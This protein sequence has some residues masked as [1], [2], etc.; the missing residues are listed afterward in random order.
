MGSTIAWILARHGFDVVVTDRDTDS[1]T[2]G[3]AR[4]EGRAKADPS[5]DGLSVLSVV[6]ARI[7]AA[8]DIESAVS[9]ADLVIEATSE[10]RD[11][12]EK[13]LR[14][15]SE[16]LPQHAILATNTSSY[17][18]D[19]LA[20]FLPASVRSRFV[21]IHFFNPADLVPGVEVI[22]HEGT[23]VRVLDT[24]ML[25]MRQIG[26]R[27]SLIR[28][29]PGFVANR[30][31]LALF[32]EAVACVDEGVATSEEIDVIVSNTFGYRLPAF[33]PFQVADM[34][35]LDV[36]VGIFEVLEHAFGARFAAP[37]SLLEMVRAGQL[38]LKSGQG[39][40]A[41]TPEAAADQIER[42]DAAYRA[43]SWAMRDLELNRTA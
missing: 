34:A 39:Y 40:S 9:G 18:I 31:Q 14:R 30:L 4:I 17:P 11:V 8:A 28:S 41:Y 5:Q 15:A 32:R 1:V 6:A 20:G 27:P 23:A 10:T 26:K 35:G 37:A 13:V 36:Y 43:I 38:G 16:A 42:R 29:S 3:L 21:G 7:T 2:A 24:C 25:L 22:A 12:K 33:G 19:L